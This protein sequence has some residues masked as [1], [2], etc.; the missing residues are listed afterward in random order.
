MQDNTV[1]GCFK[2]IPGVITQ[3]ETVGECEKKLFYIL[4]M[5]LDSERKI[6]DELDALF[7]SINEKTTIEKRKYNFKQYENRK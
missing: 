6:N 3:A 4:S 1:T 5:F 2:E 7:L